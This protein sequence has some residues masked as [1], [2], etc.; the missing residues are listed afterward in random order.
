M[1]MAYTIRYWNW[2]ARKAGVDAAAAHLPPLPA[3]EEEEGLD[4]ALYRNAV[5]RDM[6]E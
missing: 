5:P 2:K 4:K 3:L 1:M 6:A